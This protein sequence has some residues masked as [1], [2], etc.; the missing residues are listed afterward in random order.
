MATPIASDVDVQPHRCPVCGEL[1]NAPHVWCQPANR[2]KPP[3][4]STSWPTAKREDP[5][6]RGAV[7]VGEVQ[8][9]LATLGAEVAYLESLPA[10]APV[11]SAHDR[12]FRDT[13]HGRL[14]QLAGEL[15]ELLAR[16]QVARA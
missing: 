15:R 16:S 12:R 11:E 1:E 13:T 2:P 9:L 3:A 6:A 4:P 8:A 10:D 7:V 14:V 5:I